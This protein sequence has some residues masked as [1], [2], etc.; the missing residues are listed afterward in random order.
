MS[1]AL[2]P[3]L[4]ALAL[5]LWAAQ[6]WAQA[7]RVRS[8]RLEGVTGGGVRALRAEVS[9][10]L[11][12]AATDERLSATV[13]RLAAAADELAWDVRVERLD[14]RTGTAEVTFIA[15]PSVS[16]IAS[17]SLTTRA[18]GPPDSEESWRLLR[19]AQSEGRPVKSRSGQRPHP[20]F[21]RQDEATI[22]EV[23]AARGHRDAQVRAEQM[24]VNGAPGLVDLVFR[25]TPGRALRLARVSVEGLPGTDADQTTLRE[26]ITAQYA[27]D[28]RFV[29]AALAAD[30]ERLR[31][32][33]CRRGYPEARVELLTRDLTEADAV[34]ATLR[35]VA[36]PETLIGQVGFNGDA[37][38]AGVRASLHSQ[39]GR[40]WCPDLVADDK[41]TLLAWMRDHGHPDAS[42]EIGTA[43]RLGTARVVDILVGLV[44]R[45]TVVVERIGF[46][47]NR[48]TRESVLRQLLA[49]EEGDLFRQRQIDTTVQNMLR[50]GLFR[51]VEVRVLT[52][53]SSS[54]RFVV[55]AV[56][57]QD[58]V[59]VDVLGQSLTLRNVDVTHWPSDIGQL[60]SGS[61][62]R[63]AGQDIVLIGRPDYVGLRFEHRFLHPWLLLE[64]EVNRRS[65][66]FASVT[67]TYF[68]SEAGL[69]VKALENRL[70]LIPFVR[71]ERSDLPSKP[72]FEPLPV[73]LGP[74]L[75]LDVG[76]EA[77]AELSL[78]DAERIVYLGLDTSVRYA[79]AGA[80]L[81]TDITRD[82][83]DVQSALNLP[84]FEN[85][86]GAHAILR[87]TGRFAQL[88]DG[89]DVPAHD[90]VK[91]V[92]RGYGLSAIGIP[93][94][95]SRGGDPDDAGLVG[96][97]RAASAT[98]TLRLPIRPLRRNA[99]GPFIDAATVAAPGDALLDRLSVSAGALYSFSF[100]AERLE[101][102]AW[103]AYPFDGALESRYFGAGVGGSF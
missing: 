55:F 66:A 100:F 6:G 38:P 5:L 30:A 7:P 79:H 76:A 81:G 51:E 27:E 58:P 40:P 64:A 4:A 90:R 14:P 19:Q 20:Y 75:T 29:R 31:A 47:G 9:S 60:H 25:L 13:E 78:R 63:G 84:L 67:E 85:D 1:R 99:V 70:A 2:A 92:V 18:S 32:A 83:L 71:L 12:T 80:W 49:L 69:G 54:A 28:A 41:A 10:L 57:E 89:D 96:G 15:T 72:A 61:A 88:F 53:T 94:A 26:R 21:V 102:F 34:E 77:R 56:V 97:E 42:I 52:G 46:E 50:S 91:P 73:R 8:V 62:L 17:V 44:A 82:L 59:A 24:T 39:P 68:T 22:R 103:L 33:V 35:V 65:Q 98:A 101:G 36:G 93:F 95:T 3:W 48:V 16:R 23:W 87:L 86:R 74:S 45:A 43:P 11:D 37:V